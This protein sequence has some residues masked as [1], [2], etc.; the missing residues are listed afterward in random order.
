MLIHH[1]SAGVN[2][3]GWQSIIGTSTEIEQ[4]LSQRAPV[5]G[6]K[7]QLLV[8]FRPFHADMVG[9]TEKIQRRTVTPS[10]REK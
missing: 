4:M 5:F 3:L 8:Q 10:N 9:E 7:T 2:T 6:D 1:Q